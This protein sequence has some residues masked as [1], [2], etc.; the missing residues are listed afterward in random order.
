MGDDRRQLGLGHQPEPVAQRAKALGPQPHLLVGLL[1]AYE[2]GPGA[3]GGQ[4]RERLQQQ[5]GL[6][7]PG[8]AAQQGDRARHQAAPQDAVELGDAGGPRQPLAGVDVGDGRRTSTVLTFGPDV[9]D[10][11]VP[12]AAGVAL[13]RP[14]W[15]A[16]PAPTA[17][18]RRPRPSHGP[19]PT[20][21]V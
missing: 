12:V 8:L 14:P 21:G 3:V 16:G 11:R 9:F 1:A 20:Q 2:Q 4:R 5:G 6:A 18:V 10:Q 19:D 13:P 17:P 15:R 7:D